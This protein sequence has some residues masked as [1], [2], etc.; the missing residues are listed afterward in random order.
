MSESQLIL[1]SASPYR[2]QILK[3]LGLSFEQVPAD[4]DETP[5]PG[6]APAQLAHRLGLEKARKV[7][8]ELPRDSAWIVIGSDQVCHH[9]GLSYGKPGNRET[10]VGHLSRFSGDW[11]TYS[12]SLALIRND[13][14]TI[15]LV[16]DYECRFRELT[17]SEIEAY[18]DLDEPWD[19]AGSIRIEKAAAL[20]MES[21]RGRDINTLIG[22]PVM[23]LNESLGRLGHAILD[24]N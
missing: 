18:V 21:T 11:V 3:S 8:S 22:L 17:R 4:I 24:F 20:L 12:S 10:A 23:A 7:A 6:E 9:E 5:I 16:E 14:E 2:A 19:C 1:A 15:T 13:G